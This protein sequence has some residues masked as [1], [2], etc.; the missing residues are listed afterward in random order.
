[1]T[2]VKNFDRD[3]QYVSV[4]EN[5]AFPTAESDI[6]ANPI[7]RTSGLVYPQVVRVQ[8]SER[9]DQNI[10]AGKWRGIGAF[11]KAPVENRAVYRVQGS[12][13]VETGSAWLGVGIG[14]ATPSA[15]AAGQTVLYPQFIQ[16]CS[17]P[18]DFDRTICLDKFG[19]ID[20]L[21]FSNRN[22][23]FFLA[24][25]NGSGAARDIQI[26]ATM[27]IQC[28]AMANLEYEAQMR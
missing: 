17:G 25:L 24:V 1:M 6:T 16:L 5:Y 23:V 22:P 10:G 21:D 9:G 18:T 8:R 19:T 14:D 3:L 7:I 4:G 20:A 26:F 13:H 12:V 27:S 2:S 15:D 28:L 11:V